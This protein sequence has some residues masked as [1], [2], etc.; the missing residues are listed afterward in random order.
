MHNEVLF[1]F[2]RIEGQQLCE[3]FMCTKGL[4]IPSIR[5]FSEYEIFW[6]YSLVKRVGIETIVGLVRLLSFQ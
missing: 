4:E 3:N 1:N 2:N 5:E 6:I